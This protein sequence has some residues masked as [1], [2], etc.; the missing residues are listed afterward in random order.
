MNGNIWEM[1]MTI[2]YGEKIPN[3]VNLSGDRKLQRAM[4][5]WQPAYV[6]WWKSV[7]PQA[8]G[9]RDVYLRTA[10][11]TKPGGWAHFGHVKMPEYRWGIFLADPEEGRVI[12]GGDEAGKPVWQAVP[13]EHRAALKRL[14]VVQADTEPASV[15]QQRWLASTMPSLYDCRNLFQ[16]NVE[17]GRHLWAMVYLLQA[18]FG[19][20]GREEADALLERTS[21]DVDNPRILEAFNQPCTD[22]LSFFCFTAFTDRDGKYQLG[23]LAE[24][25]FDPLSR[26]CRFML[27]E[28]AHHLFVGESGIGRI[29]QR[30]A[31]LMKIDPNED[32][33][34]QGGID[35]PTIQRYINYWFSYC[36]DLFGAEES[37][38]AA[39]YF[40]AGLKAR[41]RE[42]TRYEDHHALNRSHR[43]FGVQG[44]QLV[45]RDIPLRLAMNELLRI[46]YIDDCQK[47]VD[48]W[49]RTLITE[50]INSHKF[51]LPSP[52][53]HRR[54]GN[55]GQHF[56][57][58]SGRLI[59]EDLWK[60]QRGDWLKSEA[61]D[62]Y[63]FSLMKPVT[64]PGKM[65]QYIAAPSRGINRQTIDYEYVRTDV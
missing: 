58:P 19:R 4:E 23:S 1:I 12:P 43:L 3:N 62:A 31:Q 36:L 41:W 64:E 18:Y 24:S 55:F 33:R 17:E 45:E 51:S 27:T 9:D 54:Q 6:N 65:A 42:S 30:S 15:E 7:G 28:E 29:I 56:F 52:R 35:L 48:R 38:N 57:T 39:E 53:F 34:A 22:W 2:D 11:S 63:I 40:A 25:A 50:G 16:V 32:A 21:G 61:N 44:D 14:I 46:E 20:D 47:V 8:F 60:K 26:S 10:I 37:N 59:A 49:N 5:K 13:G